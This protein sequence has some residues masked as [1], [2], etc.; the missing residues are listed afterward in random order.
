MPDIGIKGQGLTKGGRAVQNSTEG[1]IGGGFF[2]WGRIRISGHL[3]DSRDRGFKGSR[4][5][6]GV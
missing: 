4:G 5:K 1:G 6:K 2:Y 3:K